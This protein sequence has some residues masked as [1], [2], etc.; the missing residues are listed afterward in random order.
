MTSAAAD[1]GRKRKA[2]ER[3]KVDKSHRTCVTPIRRWDT[4]MGGPII[5][6]SL[7]RLGC[8]SYYNNVCHLSVDIRL[9]KLFKSRMNNPL[10][11]FAQQRNGR[12]T[13]PR[14]VSCQHNHSKWCLEASTDKSWP[15][16]LDRPFA[17]CS[18]LFLPYGKELRELLSL[19]ENTVRRPPSSYVV[20]Y[21]IKIRP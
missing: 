16:H 18:R 15:D 3:K 10:I 7:D 12:T 14:R 19:D 4:S 6:A 8:M 11:I 5:C 1:V 13:V 2:V 9:Q 21:P 20:A 17:R